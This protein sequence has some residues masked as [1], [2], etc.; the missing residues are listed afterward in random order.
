MLT[1]LRVAGAILAVLIGAYGILRFRQG[2]AGKTTLTLALVAAVLLAAVAIEPGFVFGLRDLLGISGA[3]LSGLVVALILAVGILF[4]LLLGASGRI[5][6]TRHRLDR[7]VA[8]LARKTLVVPDGTPRPG[9]AVILP[10]LNEADNLDVLLTRI[11]RQLAGLDVVAIVVDDGSTD[12]TPAIAVRDRAIVVS[13]PI[14]QG[15][16]AALRLGYQVALELGATIVVT[17]D[18]D[19]QHDPAQMER[20]V[21]PILEDR[22]DFVIGSRLKGEHEAAS[23][24]R[25]VGIYL[26]NGLISI[27]ARR[28]ITDC[29]SGYRAIRAADLDRLHLAENQF[30]TSETIL[31][32]VKAGLRL[33]E[34]PVTIARRHSGVSKKPK[35]MRYGWGFLR[36]IVRAWWR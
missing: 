17:M 11:P 24:I 32:A 20:L 19:G 30:H 36:A 18:A 5:D 29:S 13:H 4:I 33:E 14:N 3:P 25:H 2:A 10:A 35:A 8:G 21:S 34:V 6:D 26:F 15:G 28:K 7:L 9:I 22:A 27:L 12:A 1:E 31:L 16:G 23:L